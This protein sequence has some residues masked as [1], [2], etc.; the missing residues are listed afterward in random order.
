MIAAALAA[1][2]AASAPTVDPE[3]HAVTFTAEATGVATNTTLEFLFVGKGSD[4]SYEAMFE[5]ESSLEELDKAFAA[6]GIPRGTSLDAASCHLWP[7]GAELKL[8]PSLGDFVTS[9]L[10][11]R[12]VPFERIVY[13]GGARENDGSLSAATNMPLA[14]FCFYDLP[15]SPILFDGAFPQGQVYGRYT[16]K[17]VCKK[18]EPFKFT[19]SWDG[20]T[21]TRKLTV[22][23]TVENAA[24]ELLKL[25]KAAENGDVEVLVRFSPWMTV[26]E[27]SQLAVALAQIDSPHVKL[28]GKD[29]LFYRAFLPLE[30]WRDRKERLVQP[31]ELHLKDEGKIALVTIDE[32]WSGDTPDPK[33]TVHEQIMTFDSAVAAATAT[34]NRSDTLFVYANAGERL[35]RLYSLV[36]AIKRPIA[37]WYVLSE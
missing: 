37:N 29:K 20:K 26:R 4:R 24:Q 15:Q 34:K 1:L 36:D 6:A 9:A 32:D 13:T 28:N 35:E 21:R 33:L 7:A 3:R 18:G 11:G 31:I 30:K 14:A 23:F 8:E 22:D 17:K 19:L 16:C 5:L 12:E 10:N 25:K 2:L 27:A